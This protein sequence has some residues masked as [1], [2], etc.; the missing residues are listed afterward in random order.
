MA[1]VNTVL[2]PLD[3]SNLGFTLGHEHVITGS[4]G[5]RETFPEFLPRQETIEEAVLQLGEAHAGGLETLVEMS[6]HDLGRDIRGLEEISRRSGVHIIATTGTWSDIPRVFWTANPDRIAALYVREIEV[7]IEETGIKAGVIK[8][9][10]NTRELEPQEVIVLRAVARTHKKT[11]VTISTHA[12]S[13]E[14]AGEAQVQIFEEE[15]VDLSRV[16]IG[17]S[18]D[19]ADMDYLLGLLRKGVYLGLDHYPG[20]PA[21]EPGL[22]WEQRTAVAKQLIDAGYAHRIIF[23]HDYAIRVSRTDPERMRAQQRAR[24]PHGYLFITRQVLPRLR[25]LGVSEETIHTITVD[26][27]RRLFGG[28]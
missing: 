26:N 14:R 7:G 11:G 2:G 12:R 22:D 6:T 18:N 5:I 13:P 1:T 4:P 16:Y 3:T 9:A 15:R 21:G 17:H 27:P 8:A 28:D 23:G 10:N 19:T 25:E 24:N 20:T